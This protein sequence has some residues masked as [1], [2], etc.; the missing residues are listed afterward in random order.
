VIPQVPASAWSEQ[1]S[2]IV[3]VLDKKTAAPLLAGL[4][5]QPGAAPEPAAPATGA[6]LVPANV[7]PAGGSPDQ[8][9]AMGVTDPPIPQVEQANQLLF[10]T[11]Y[12]DSVAA[13]KAQGG[14]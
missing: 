10:R 14:R 12:Y 3:L 1:D 9:S 13:H 6:P 5:Q 8:L 11:A 4:L 7:P 2:L